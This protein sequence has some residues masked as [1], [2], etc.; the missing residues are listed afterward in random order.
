[1]SEIE[2]TA[3]ATQEVAKTANTGIEVVRDFGSYMSQFITPPLEQVSDLIT[4][5]LKYYTWNNKLNL[6]QKTQ[7][8]IKE[9]GMSPQNNIPQKLLIPLL[10]AASLEEDDRLQEL[11]VNLLVNS[12]TGFSLERSYIS[13]LEQLSPLEAQILIKIYSSISLECNYPPQIDISQYPKIKIFK[14]M[15]D[16]ESM[17]YFDNMNNKNSSINDKEESKEYEITDL[18]LAFSNLIRL[19]CLLM[20]STFGGGENFRGVYPTIF[21]AKLYE[22]VNEPKI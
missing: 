5:K 4:D 1:M 11:W 6:M 17:V 14:E 13:V 12:S 15:T 3:K 20:I 21:G 8:K 19:N 10:E 7:E 16:E 9:L 18:N 2:E 22:A